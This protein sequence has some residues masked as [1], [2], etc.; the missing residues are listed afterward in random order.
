MAAKLG[1]RRDGPYVIVKAVSPTSYEIAA[2][3]NLETPLGKYHVQDLTPCQGGA[4][5]QA[6]V[7]LRKRGRPRKVPNAT[8]S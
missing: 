7:P 8:T 4:D 6:R 5:E 3:D 1:P 2:P